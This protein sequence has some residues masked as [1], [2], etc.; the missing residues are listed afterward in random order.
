MGVCYLLWIQP[1]Y[2][3]AIK[4]LF[5]VVAAVT[6]RKQ[7]AGL[8]SCSDQTWTTALALVCR[9]LSVTS[10]AAAGRGETALKSAT[11]TG[12]PLSPH[13]PPDVHAWTARGGGLVKVVS[14]L[15]DW[16]RF[17]P[18]V[19]YNATQQQPPLLYS[20]RCW[21]FLHDWLYS[22]LAYIINMVVG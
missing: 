12:F 1:L 13:T 3:R 15:W 2:P 18:K 19:S 11:P 17:V 5:G 4:T 22:K 10:V 7:T 8:D 9:S 20:N 6:N 21:T 16:S 14:K